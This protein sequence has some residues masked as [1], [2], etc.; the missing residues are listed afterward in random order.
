MA[1]TSDALGGA[2]GHA[3]DLAQRLAARGHAVSLLVRTGAAAVA[4]AARATGLPVFEAA[5]YPEVAAVVA[6]TEA[7]VVQHFDS[8]VVVAGLDVAARRPASVQVLH[9]NHALQPGL[10]AVPTDEAD[11]VVAVSGSVARFAPPG[12]PGPRVIPNG[13]DLARFTPRPGPRAPGPL[14]VLGVGRIDEAAK[15]WRAVVAACAAQPAGTV[16]LHLLG[17][18]PDAAALAAALPT[19]ARLERGWPDPVPAYQAADVLLSASAS[20]GFGLALAEAAAC[21]LAVV[22]RRC[23]G[24]SEAMEGCAWL[25]DDDAGLA[26]G[27]ARV[28]EDAGLRARL[29]AAA[30]AF[31]AAS[32]AL[33]PM[34]DAY[35]RA[36]ADAV[37]RAEGARR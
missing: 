21:G 28:R 10:R 16:A 33:E 22:A 19:W 14:R 15:R 32:L 8:M 26:A 3:L 13:L 31:A 18:G 23:H 35:E 25:A 2:E 36:H 4:G 9:A 20:E 17:E 27:L 30:R 11:V 6:A 7:E 37:A 5:T 1:V 12:G 34:V 29:G 24:L